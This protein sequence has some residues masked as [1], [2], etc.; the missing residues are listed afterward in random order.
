[1]KRLLSVCMALVLTLTLSAIAFAS[2][3]TRTAALTLTYDGPTE[4][5]IGESITGVTGTVL[6]YGKNIAVDGTYTLAD[7][8]YTIAFTDITP[9]TTGLQTFTYTVTMTAANPTGK[10]SVTNTWIGTASIVV[11]V[12]PLPVA[13]PVTEEK[14]C[15]GNDTSK[16]VCDGQNAGGVN[17]PGQVGTTPDNS[18]NK[19]GPRK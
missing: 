1:M 11:N 15:G 10:N 6:K 3:D 12:K 14:D 16:T 5:F 7:G 4:I 8:Y 17:A 13:D 2:S 9:A 18:G 19:G